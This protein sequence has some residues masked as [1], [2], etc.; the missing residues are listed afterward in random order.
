M[1]WSQVRKLN[2]C[3]YFTVGGH[4][5]NHPILSFLND[6]EAKKEIYNSIKAI[7]KKTK[8]KVKHYSYPEG[9]KNTFG[10]REIKLLKN[11][12]ISICPSSEFGFNNKYTDL[13]YL[14]R[15]FVNS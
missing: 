4:T 1:N 8:I 10:K 3:E 7:E 2:K 6:R 14:K 5:I 11:R 12:G 13:F 15:I 9:L